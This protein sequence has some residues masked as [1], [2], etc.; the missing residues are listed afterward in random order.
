MCA[1]VETLAKNK[2]MNFILVR[3]K[4]K[5]FMIQKIFTSDLLDF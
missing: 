1:Y 2:F 5:I 3:L 4:K